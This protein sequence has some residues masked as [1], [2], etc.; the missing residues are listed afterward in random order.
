[1][2]QLGRWQ[3]D[4]AVQAALESVS[5]Q[6][7]EILD[8]AIS[9]QQVPAPTF[10]E[11]ERAAFIAQLMREIGLSDV[12]IDGVSNVYGRRVGKHGGPGIMIAAHSDTVFPANT[13]LEIRIEGERVY[14]PGLGDNSLGVAALLTLAK[15]YQEFDLHNE[16][17]IW[18][19][20]DVGEEGLGDLRGMRAAVDMLND[21][22]AYA[23]A[24][25]GSGPEH[26]VNTGLG[27]LRYRVTVKTAGGHSWGDFG[28][29]SAVHQLVELSH[30]LLASYQELA[31]P[32]S[33]YNIGT[34]EGGTSVNT[35][36]QQASFLLDLRS[37]EDENLLKLREATEAVIA[38][39][40][41]LDK[42]VTVVGE[43]VGNRPAGQISQD[44]PLAQMAYQAYTSY[45]FA[46][47]FVVASTDANV[48]LSR[49]IPAVCVG[50]CDGYNAHRLDEYVE[51][52]RLAAGMQALLLLSLGASNS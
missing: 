36:A 21:K 16:G 25:E 18:F 41:A 38:K 35:I 49:G 29:P 27:S 1:M 34:I 15:L 44:H 3:Q 52:K 33:S 2:S 31:L 22:I 48:P 37:T 24:L 7:E 19:V 12:Q 32:K 51:I 9:I 11:Q 26:I 6:A 8:L 42:K 23:I 10:A 45:G 20:S 50:V 40:Q 28:S 43:L 17:D 5:Y 39:Y 30:E 13:D 4:A 47:E 14:G 46:A